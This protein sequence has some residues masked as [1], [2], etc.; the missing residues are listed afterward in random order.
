MDALW[1]D[2]RYA[3]RT[4]LRTPGFTAVAVLS[5]SLGIGATT[6]AFSVFNAVLLRPLPV[7]QPARLALVMAERRGEHYVLFNPV[8]EEL[9]RRQRTFS[10]MFAVSDEPFLKLAFADDTAPAYV[11]GSFVSGSYFSVLGLSPSLGRLLGEADDVIGGTSGGRGCA[12]VISH[13]F[14]ERRFRR[15]PTV[16]GR[17]LRVREVGCTLVGVAPPGFESHQ[18]GYSTDVW[19]PLRAVTDP[20]L[21][22]SHGMAFFSGVIGR[23]RPGATAGQAEAELT[24]LYRQIVAG[25][26]APPPNSG[27]PPVRPNDFRI[28]LASGAQG[29]DSLRREFAEPLRI[30]VAVVGLVLLIATFNVAHLTL[31]RGTTRSAELATR[32]ALGAGRR[33]LVR[34]LATE[35]S[36]LALIGGL[37]GVALASLGTPALA[38]LLSLRYMTTS[39]DVRADGRVVA[40]AVAVTALAALLSGILPAVRL[41]RAT[42]SPGTAAERRIVGSRQRN[43]LTRVLVA[44]QLSLSLLLVSAAG[45]LLRTMLRIS[46]IDPGFDVERVVV[47]DVRDEN[48]ASSFGAADPPEE[49]ARRA[50]LY[51]LLDEHLNVLPGVQAAALSW[52][53]LFGGS[54]LWL[55]LIDAERPDDRPLARVDYVSARYFDTVGMQVLHG[56][57]FDDRDRE[58][59]ER[60]AVV[61]Q[62]LVRQRFAGAEALGRRLALDYTGEQDRP[63][64]VVGVVRDSKY[65]DLREARVEP[66]MWVPLAQ[67]PFRI[68]SVALRV[69]PGAAAAVTRQATA[70]LG[71]ADA[72]LMV[73]RVTTLAAQVE[74]TTARERLLLAFAAG[75]GC[76]ALLLAAVGLYGTLAYAVSGR[77]REIGVRLALGA[78]PRTVLRMVLSEAWALVVGA[79]LV[80]MPL[81]VGGGQILRAFLF[82]VAPQDPATLAGAC[83]VLALVATLAAYVPARR[84][85]AVDPMVA[86]RYE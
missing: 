19:V 38:S 68:T 22:A 86:L 66:M 67:A 47:L 61:N 71:E 84:A 46:A 4:L 34:Q 1:Q 53:G 7:E 76:L 56:R 18:A 58:G 2:L 51:R 37:F 29:L 72:Q 45:L 73:R 59:T 48:P 3:C 25:E 17:A 15:D 9:R 78:E 44:A 79:F 43:R 65:N 40:V 49:K 33:R 70:T 60:V 63:F 83:A 41:S 23:L 69:E 13:S 8:L 52:L 16:L 30:A 80:G 35:G 21:L 39:L 6:A 26:P 85:A 12:V 77:T 64:T 50:A 20:K 74:D 32:M 57:G 14:W 36:L 82:G 42:L 28:R 27:Q 75:F 5:L 10:G 24:L 55:S 62:A 54:D 81:A 11:R 31:A